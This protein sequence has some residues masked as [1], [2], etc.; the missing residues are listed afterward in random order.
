[1]NF[2]SQCNKSYG[3]KTLFCPIHGC[4]LLQDQRIRV[5]GRVIDN[6]YEV[7]TEVGEG[8]TGTVYRARHVKLD[9]T[10]ALKILHPKFSDDKV[11]VERFRRE[12]YASMQIRHPNAIA[13]MDFGIT[14]DN[15]VYVVMEFLVGVTLR[16]RLD[17]K[18]ILNLD[19]ANHFLQP[20]CEAVQV[21][22]RD[23]KPEN[24]FLDRKNS[25][26]G[27]ETIKVLDF[28]IARMMAVNE[29]QQKRAMRLTQDGIIIGT[30]HYMSPEQCYGRDVDARSDVYAVG[31]IVYE[32]LTGEVP[33]DDRSLS[34]IAVR[35][36]REK[37]RPPHYVNPQIPPLVSAVI[38]H[39]IEK[40][41]DNRPASVK[42]FAQEFNSVVRLVKE[43][44]FHSLFSNASDADLE[45]ALLLANNPLSAATRLLDN[46]LRERT[47]APPTPSA[48]P[49]A[50][51]P[52][53]PS[54]GR[55]M[56]DRSILD[57]VMLDRTVAER[58]I[59]PDRPM[60]VDDTLDRTEDTL[61][62]TIEHPI[63]PDSTPSPDVSL[64]PNL[65]EET[66]VPERSP[67][68]EVTRLLD[69]TLS[70]NSP[71]TEEHIVP[72]TQSNF[73]LSGA[74]TNRQTGL[75]ASIP[76]TTTYLSLSEKEFKITRSTRV[77]SFQEDIPT[78]EVSE[79]T[80]SLPE[81]IDIEN[82]Y[83]NLLHFTTET[84]MLMQIISADLEQRRPIDLVFL[85]ELKN[86]VDHM[87][88]LLHRLEHLSSLVNPQTTVEE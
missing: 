57:R 76:T 56:L 53:R 85:Q 5:L 2:C 36:A 72:N 64:S 82:L 26:N 31:I 10:V 73:A 41:A 28:G 51:A 86:A 29:E 20:I 45:A 50:T 25:K 55:G 18:R 81:P 88:H 4:K 13:V 39:A 71:P 47:I 54:A 59:S 63:S 15:L 43:K 30:P 16:D 66:L 21:A 19:E 6:K 79:I 69:H 9:L 61:D 46:E 33:F 62:R 3:I 42:A 11:A 24:I 7:E 32:M 23:L 52:A 65:F 67:S 22:H 37:P 84:P 77:L 49:S 60:S 87:R 14:D 70:P 35:Q 75:S 48:T 74:P 12:A 58:M 1:M 78:I 38:M 17:Q 40:K 8:G 68:S 83:N 27:E 80:N 44:E 34:V